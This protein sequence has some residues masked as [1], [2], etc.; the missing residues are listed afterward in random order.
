MCWPAHTLRQ[1]CL[2]PIP[3]LHHISCMFIEQ[4]ISLCLLYVWPHTSGTYLSVLHYARESILLHWSFVPCIPYWPCW[5]ALEAGQVWREAHRRL[6]SQVK[7]FCSCTVP[8]RLGLIGNDPYWQLQ[9]QETPYASIHLEAL[10]E[11]CVVLQLGH[12]R[13]SM[14]GGSDTQRHLPL[15]QWGSWMLPPRVTVAWRLSLEK[16]F[17]DESAKR[18][19]GVLVCSQVTEDR[20]KALNSDAWADSG[21]GFYQIPERKAH[22]IGLVWEKC[23]RLCCHHLASRTL[24]HTRKHLGTN[25]NYKWTLW[26]YLLL[27]QVT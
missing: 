12:L 17:A 21:S 7:M 16:M 15:N 5:Q 10:A 19:T 14:T 9:D 27:I 3:V 20:E 8:E 18:T 22:I 4:C 13:Q 1:G 26:T 11:I 23:S 24:T 25:I 6:V 2:L